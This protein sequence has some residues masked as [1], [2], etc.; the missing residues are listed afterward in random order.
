MIDV[1]FPKTKKQI[2]FLEIAKS[3]L[4]AFEKICNENDLKFIL[5]FGTLLGAI[6]DKNFIFFDDDVD[7]TINYFDE[8][9]F[10]SLL[11]KFQKAGFEKP[12]YIKKRNFY[13]LKRNG[14]FLDVFIAKELNEKRCSIFGFTMPKKF[15]CETIEIEFIGKK[16]LI[17]KD[18]D[19]FLKLHY[20]NGYFIPQKFNKG[21]FQ[22]F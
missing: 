7:V 18:Y 21:T 8:D 4:L 22:N 19:E 9:K 3:N 13:K 17:P 20:G 16:F 15:I 11:P 14:V 10:S 12:I 1:C 5:Y 6:R 2:E